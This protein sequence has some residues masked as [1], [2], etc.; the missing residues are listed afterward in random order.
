MPLKEDDSVEPSLIF[1]KLKV[2][3]VIAW[4][5]GFQTSS[6][7]SCRLH[8]FEYSLTSPYRHLSITDSSF[9]ARKAKNHTFPTSII[10][11]PL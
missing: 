3:D 1:K 10:R 2:R 7:F 4:G 5:W 8:V 6:S 11:T 9:A